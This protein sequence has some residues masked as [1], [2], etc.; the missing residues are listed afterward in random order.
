[1]INSQDVKKDFPL[2]ASHPD[3]VYLDS[4]ATA[5][6]PKGVRD[7][8]NEYLTQ[9]STNISRGLYP[10]AE[11][12]TEKF[13]ATRDKVA[14]FI[15]ANPQEIIF[16]AGAT[17]SINLA[18]ALL[19]DRIKPGDN[20]V[21]TEMEHHSN[22]L[23]WKE[24]AQKSGCEFRV[25]T[26]APNG[27][28]GLE[29]LGD[30]LDRHT[31]IVAFP[32]VSNVLGTINPTKDIVALVKKINPG[33]LVVVDAAQAVG[34][35][36]LDVSAWGADFVAFS[37]HK[38]F[39]PTGVGVL[40]GRQSLLETL[41]PVTFGGGM[42]LDACAEHPV[43]KD[44]PYRFEAGTPNISGV[45]AFGAAIEY[46]ESIGIENIR[47]HDRALAAYSFLRLREAFG[48]AIHIIGPESSAERS[49]IIA[50]AFDGMHPHDIAQL[51]G[52]EN[53][54][55]RAGE[56]CAAPLHR[57]L[58]LAATTRISFSI[59]NSEHDVDRL[60]EKLKNI[61]LILK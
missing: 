44:T 42:V 13:E 27:T 39:G 19:A 29:T 31:K 6:K 3:L 48:D 1:M 17:A 12:A 50:F 24:L 9:Y 7:A 53:I 52:E 25:A 34:H 2:F 21:V 58:D 15:G 8:L 40:F 18:A 28:L 60:I 11:T 22:Y 37:A 16:T 32:A 4:A 61:S 54:C 55:V 38:M 46:I 20:I 43:Y 10:L 45:I 59:Y 5:L 33:V 47:A 56:H 36:P 23:P 35:L 49:G 14:A 51:L 41:S 26:L 57:A 30:V